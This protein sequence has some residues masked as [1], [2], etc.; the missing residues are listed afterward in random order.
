MMKKSKGR[1]KSKQH[2]K[3][4]IVHSALARNAAFVK[5]HWPAFA[6]HHGN[7]S[8]NKIKA[9][10]V[11]VRSQGLAPKKKSRSRSKSHHKKAHHHHAK[12]K[13]KTHHKKAHHTKAKSKSKS[14]SH[15]KRTRSTSSAR[16]R[17]IHKLV[18]MSHTPY[19]MQYLMGEP[20]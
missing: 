5:K 3:K 16:R 19:A 6:R 8:G 12:S 9:F 7:K 1:S 15:P 13:S 20:L 11:W 18:G 17:A 14:K 4:R 10:W 2:K